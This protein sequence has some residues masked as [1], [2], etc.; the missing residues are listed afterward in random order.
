MYMLSSVSLMFFSP[1]GSTE[2]IARRICKKLSDNIIEYDLTDQNVKSYNFEHMDTVLVAVPVFGGRVPQIAINNIKKFSSNGAKV[3]S[4]VIYGNRNY[5]DALVELNDLLIE[6]GFIVIAS[7]AFIAQH[8]IV[9]E[10]GS[11]R[12]DKEDYVFI[13]QFTQRVI[14]KI[15]NHEDHEITV[16]GNRPY[17][18]FQSIPIAPLTSSSCIKCGLCIKRCP[19]NAIN[20]SC[21]IIPEKCILCMRCVNICA[22]KARFLPE[23]FLAKI[24]DMLKLTA[25]NRKNNEMFL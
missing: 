10:I 11:K 20:D 5:D 8:S 24:R 19:A 12:P 4:I 2:K 17:K 22:K 7:G 23:L 9:K 13:D 25:I 6:Y 15:I 1:V 3:I 18:H 14:D 21:E 16:P